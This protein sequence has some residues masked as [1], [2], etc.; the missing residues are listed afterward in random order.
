MQTKTKSSFVRDEQDRIKE[1]IE[2]IMKVARGDYYV[3]LKLSG[4]NDELDSLA[5]G[6][7]MM[8]DDINYT[9][10]E[11]KKATTYINA[12]G[13]GLIVLDM[14]TKVIKINKATEKILG[15][16]QKD[17]P[18]LT[19]ES[20]TAKEELPKHADLMK[21]CIQEGVTVSFETIFLTK[22]QKRIPVMLSGTVMKDAQGTPTGFVGV[23]RD[24]TKRKQAEEEGEKLNKQV[25]E[26]VS[27]MERFSKF[28]I[29]REM[30]M[31]D[32]KKEVNE[33]CKRLG[34]KSRY[35]T[36]RIE[37]KKKPSK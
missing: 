25:V 37:N 33:L 10:I 3:Q 7:N 8:I 16:T 32:L 18:E 31:V 21:K 12:M 13:D 24:I 26:K 6:I 11:Q 29:G 20:F 4:K 35:D 28:T 36:K 2:T 22:Q 14:K 1:M 19:L 17:I 30:Q 27:E 15:F 5:V 23:F 34:E 9:L